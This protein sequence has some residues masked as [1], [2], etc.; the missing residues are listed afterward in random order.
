MGGGSCASVVD[1]VARQK[2]MWRQMMARRMPRIKL[3]PGVDERDQNAGLDSEVWE[4]YDCLL[5]CLGCGY[6]A[7]D[8]GASCPGCGSTTW[9]D[10]RRSVD[11]DAI[12]QMERRNRQTV[13]PRPPAR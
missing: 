10:L 7:E 8:D 4:P 13:P 5:L 2:Y 12:R 3:K 11:A 1:A 6:L 9:V